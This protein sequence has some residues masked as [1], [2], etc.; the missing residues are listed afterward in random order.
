[1]PTSAT[2]QSFQSDLLAVPRSFLLYLIVGVAGAFALTAAEVMTRMPKSMS[3]ASF[4]ERLPPTSQPLPT[5]S[6]PLDPEPGSTM[7]Q[8][9]ASIMRRERTVTTD[10]SATVPMLGMRLFPEQDF[11]AN[12]RLH[13]TSQLAFVPL[14]LTAFELSLLTDQDDGPDLLASDALASL[15]DDLRELSEFPEMPPQI[16]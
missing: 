2:L 13:D 1:M 8:T 9:S 7:P 10:A 6:R 3:P 4:E 15:K 11:L 12:F 16:K 14:P 5:R